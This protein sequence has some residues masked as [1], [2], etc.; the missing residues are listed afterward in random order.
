MDAFL[1][2]LSVFP[3]GKHDDWLDAWT[4]APEVLSGCGAPDYSMFTAENVAKLE[5]FLSPYAPCSDS[6]AG[7]AAMVGSE[8]VSIKEKA[9]QSGKNSTKKKLAFWTC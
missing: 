7:V 6:S 5:R 8:G 1:F 9:W 3:R 2:E 4:Q